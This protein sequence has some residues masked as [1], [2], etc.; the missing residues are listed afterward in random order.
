MVNIYVNKSLD[1]PLGKLCAQVAHGA[2]KLLLDRFELIDDKLIMSDPASITWFNE[3]KTS[4]FEFE[5]KH[6]DFSAENLSNLSRNCT[7]APIIDQGRTCFNG[8][9]TATVFGQT[10]TILAEYDRV[11][12]NR[13]TEFTTEE[14]RQ[15]FILNRSSQDIGDFDLVAKNIT[16]LSIKNLLQY[17]HEIDGQY[18][19]DLSENKDLED[20]LLGSFAKITL[21][22]KSEIKIWNALDKI[23]EL[24]VKFKTKIINNNTFASIGPCRKSLIES[25]TKKMQ[26]L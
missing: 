7:V 23:K 3:W 25:I 1:M 12:E 9:L 26:L 15:V 14:S 2:M 8:V 6:I 4:F 11:I 5:I 22:L 24:D 17:M 13:S 19:F 16:L 10:D 18:T 20:W 21:S